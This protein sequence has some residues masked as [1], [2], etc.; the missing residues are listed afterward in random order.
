MKTL[1]KIYWICIL[2]CLFLVIVFDSS[3]TEGTLGFFALAILIIVPLAIRL[4]IGKTSKASADAWLR[5]RRIETNAD[6]VDYQ[7]NMGIYNNMKKEAESLKRKASY[8]GG[9]EK[10][11]LLKQAERLEREAQKYY[12]SIL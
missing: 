3:T 1:K 11:E 4:K 12:R 7:T 10:K 8:T 6:F 9:Y 5:D 2:I